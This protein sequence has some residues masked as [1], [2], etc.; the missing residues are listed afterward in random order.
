M[1]SSIWKSFIRPFPIVDEKYKSGNNYDKNSL[2]YLYKN[3]HSEN[4]HEIT[5]LGGYL[6]RPL[7]YDAVWVLANA[8]NKTLTK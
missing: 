6:E 5:K 8:L 7:A 3:L 2:I 1:S 4:Y